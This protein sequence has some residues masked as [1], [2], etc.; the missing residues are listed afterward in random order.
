MLPAFTEDWTSEE[1]RQTNAASPVIRQ[2]ER[3]L[4]RIDAGEDI[5]TRRPSAHHWPELSEVS[6]YADPRC[7][8]SLC[9]QM[10]PCA[11]FTT[12]LLAEL[13]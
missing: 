5:E 11:R 13:P 6:W 10:T 1:R 2:A 9:P 7:A 3:T 4:A 8:G 12:S